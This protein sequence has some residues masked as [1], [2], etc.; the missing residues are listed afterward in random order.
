[1]TSPTAGQ[2]DAVLHEQ[3]P[4]VPRSARDTIHGHVRVSFL[5]TVDR[6][7]NVVRESPENS[8]PS[9]YFARLAGNAARQWKFAPSNQQDARQWVLHFEFS[10]TGTTATATRGHR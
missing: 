3:I 5:V 1:V 7:G 2:H 6:A 9:A 8:G 4:D 10:R